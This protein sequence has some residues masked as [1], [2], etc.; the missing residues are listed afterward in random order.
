MAT[1][2]DTVA[3]T[4]SSSTRPPSAPSARWTGRCRGCASPAGA[5]RTPPPLGS[6]GP[7]PVVHVTEFT[8]GCE[9]SRDL[10][11]RFTRPLAGQDHETCSRFTRPLAGQDHET[12]SRF[13]RPLAGQAHGA[14][15]RD[16]QAGS[17]DLLVRDLPEA[18]WADNGDDVVAVDHEVP[19]QRRE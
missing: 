10:Q 15:S 2:K 5:A 17:R 11:G 12:C 19:L 18:K 8:D 4:P 9:G 13:T 3:S 1:E 6:R 7:R 16:L 14:G